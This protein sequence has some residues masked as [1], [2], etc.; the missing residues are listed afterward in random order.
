MLQQALEFWARF[1]DPLE[2]SWHCNHQSGGRWPMPHQLERIDPCMQ[3]CRVCCICSTR[4]MH[5]FG[6]RRPHVLQGLSSSIACH[7]RAAIVCFDRIAAIA[8]C[9][10]LHHVPQLQVQHVS[11][12]MTGH[13]HR[14]L[15]CC[16]DVLERAYAHCCVPAVTAAMHAPL[17]GS[18]A[19]MQHAMGNACTQAVPMLAA[20]IH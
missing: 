15:M 19:P 18:C 5:G 13:A 10:R 14:V 4:C 7:A 6:I 3:L 12:L 9:C 20:H 16:V 8:G 2:T 11:D 17:G 1:V